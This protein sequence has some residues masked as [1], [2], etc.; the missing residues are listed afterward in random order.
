MSDDKFRVT[1]DSAR[2]SRPDPVDFS[3]YRNLSPIQ[4]SD[5]TGPTGSFGDP[6]AVGGT[7]TGTDTGA[8]PGASS[9]TA[10]T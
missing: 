1:D 7:F 6:T 3:H 2:D 4:F 8:Y 9:W 10:S 5:W